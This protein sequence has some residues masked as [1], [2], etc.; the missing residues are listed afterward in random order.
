MDEMMLLSGKT[1]GRQGF[2]LVELLVV[3]SIVGML[4]ALLLPAVQAARE[5][6]RKT[7]CTNRMRQIGIAI[8]NRALVHRGAFPE[9]SHTASEPDKGWIYQLGPYT[10]NVDL[11]RICPDDPKADLRIERKH[12]S[13]VLNA[14]VTSEPPDR[15]GADN[16]NKLK[17]TS[18]TVMLFELA[19]HMGVNNSLDH[20]HSFLWFSTKNILHKKVYEAIQDEI[21]TD[22]HMDTAHYLYADGHVQTIPSDQIHSWAVEPW[23]FVLPQ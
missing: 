7:Q 9:T 19:D 10:E 15:K 23:N 6:G 16:I 11:I 20:V 8:H 22:R 1:I 5:M 2:T 18:K 14:Y 4:L 12:T 21:T 3:I 13:Y 17:A